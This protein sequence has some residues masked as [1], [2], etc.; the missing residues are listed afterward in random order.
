MVAVFAAAA[1]ASAASGKIFTIPEILNLEIWLS[2]S[3]LILQGVLYGEGGFIDEAEIA[4][5]K[6]RLWS[7]APPQ[8]EGSIS[9]KM[10]PLDVVVPWLDCG[11]GLNTNF[12][13]LWC[14]RA[15]L[16]AKEVYLNDLHPC[17]HTSLHEAHLEKSLHAFRSKYCDAVSLTGKPC[18]HQRHD[19]QTHTLTLL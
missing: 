11:R 4:R 15:L 6:P 7:T 13:T 1:A 5:K 17:Y 18:M 14:E 12:S 19:V 10:E 16:A 2:S 9:R 8:V 3:Q